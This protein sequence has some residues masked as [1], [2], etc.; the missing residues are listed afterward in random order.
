MQVLIMLSGK[1]RSGKNT[2]AGMLK[3]RLGAVEGSI[4]GPLKRNCRDDFRALSEFMRSQ[5]QLLREKLSA[6]DLAPFAWMDA[7]DEQFFEDKTPLTRILLQVYGL[8]IFRNRVDQDYWIKAFLEEAAGREDRLMVVTDVRFPGEITNAHQH[9]QIPTVVT[10]RV[11]R[12]GYGAEEGQGHG[13]ETAL[14]DYR[15]FNYVI[16]NDGDLK[17]LRRKVDTLTARIVAGLVSE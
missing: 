11:E 7:R 2:V 14:D 15:G 5:Y 8:E 16:V 1:L 4:A 6:E 10:V 9:P 3:E 17:S 12:P 13:S